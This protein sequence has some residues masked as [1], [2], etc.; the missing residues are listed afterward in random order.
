MFYPNPDNEDGMHP[1]YVR[2]MVSS[3]VDT[4]SLVLIDRASIGKV[5]PSD[6]VDMECDGKKQI[7][8]KDIDGSMLGAPG[9]IISDSAF[10]WDD[11]SHTNR[12]LGD[13]RIPKTLLTASNGARIPVSDLFDHRGIPGNEECTYKSAWQAFDCHTASAPDFRMLVIESMDSDTETRRLSP[14]AITSGRTID[15]NN[16]RSIYLFLS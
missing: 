5:N 1:T 13:Y 10:A 16:G 8:I 12:G 6:C 4:D 14:V 3:N 2:N 9:G 7:L 11:S 15:L